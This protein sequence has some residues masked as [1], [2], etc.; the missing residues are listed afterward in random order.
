MEATNYISIYPKD[1]GARIT[2]YA[3]GVHGQT[4]EELL[5]LAEKDYPDNACVEQSTEDWNKAIKDELWYDGK[6]GKMTKPPEP[7]EEESRQAALDALDD[8]YARKFDSLESEMA[9]ANA[10]GD[11]D[12]LADLSEERANLVNEYESKRGEI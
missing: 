7:T 9:K 8:E 11:K 10:I 4:V 5:T 1:G 2:S 3:I 6:T 12:Y